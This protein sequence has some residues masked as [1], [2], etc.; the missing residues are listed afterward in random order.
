MV[1]TPA[2]PGSCPDLLA[3]T[4]C[5]SAPA[6]N[7]VPVPVSTRA[8]TPVSS[9]LPGIPGELLALELPEQAASPRS[10]ENPSACSRAVVEFPRGR[11]DEPLR[12]LRIGV[13]YDDHVL[14]GRERQPSLQELVERTSLLLRVAD[15]LDDFRARF[16]G[17]HCRVIRAVVGYNEHQ[18]RR[19]RLPGHRAQRVLDAGGLVVRRN[20]HGNNRF[21]AHG[22]KMHYQ[23][24]VAVIR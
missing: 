14:I 11:L 19:L 17:E 22:T 10:V 20:Q 23:S 24:S 6:R 9:E 2:P 4:R 7:A 1:Y 15:R 21:I 3:A 16:T 13:L 5:F 18:V 8:F 12:D